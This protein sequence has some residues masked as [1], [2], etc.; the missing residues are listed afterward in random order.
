MLCFTADK[1]GRI[2]KVC[3][4]KQFIEKALSG[5]VL[6]AAVAIFILA[7]IYSRRRKQKIVRKYG[8]FEGLSR[9]ISLRK[10]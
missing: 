2:S 9:E 10:V 8:L 3:G 1:V 5:V 7:H 4:M 6:L